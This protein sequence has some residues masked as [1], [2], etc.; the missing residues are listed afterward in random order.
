M[1]QVGNVWVDI[2]GDASGLKRAAQEGQAAVEDL[3]K[4]A[5]QKLGLSGVSD[6]F[7]RLN[8]DLLTGFSQ[9]QNSAN[10]AS[11]SVSSLALAF[12]GLNQAIHVVKQA[13]GALEDAWDFLEEGSRL[14]S[15]EQASYR[16]AQAYDA[17]MISIVASIKEA[18]FNTI[19][20]YDAMK[21][22]NLAMTMGISTNASEI[23]NLMEISIERGRAFGLTT[24][25][26]FDRITRGIG[27]RSTRILDDL[28]FT[29]NAIEAN[30]VYA[31][32]LGIS[33]KELTDDMKVRALFN[34]ILEEGNAELE[35]QG[36]LTKDISTPYQKLATSFKTLMNEAKV[37]ASY[38][39]GQFISSP[40]ETVKYEEQLSSQLVKKGAGYAAYFLSQWRLAIAAD[41]QMVTGITYLS[42][43]QYTE[44][45]RWYG[46]ANMQ[47]QGAQQSV[48]NYSSALEGLNSEMALEIGLAGD[49]AAAQETYDE[50]MKK[51]GRS[52]K[53]QQAAINDLNE[54][55]EDFIL[56]TL[57]S[58]EVAPEATIGIAYAFGEIDDQSLAAF[59]AINKI[60]EMFEVGSDDWIN[61]LENV[62]NRMGDLADLQIGDKSATITIYIRYLTS[63][64]LS[65]GQ[66]AEAGRLTGQYNQWVQENIGGMHGGSFVG[67]QH[68]GIVP[69]GFSNDGFPLMVSSGERVDV[70]PAGNKIVDNEILSKK[71]D[72]LIS[73]MRGLPVEIRDNL[74]MMVA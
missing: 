74:R 46:M 70:T 30:R 15:L 73:V 41:E 40:E 39:F 60:N 9:T 35:K 42:K 27:R 19:T 18:S 58:L 49:L 72:D 8:K 43:S 45:Q 21:A 71:M 47:A 65:S 12:T 63:G 17:N 61:A 36:G 50:A 66:A 20:E 31:E 33:T 44:A 55:Y 23:S 2:G 62:K 28:G 25:E 59:G 38:L 56:N 51:A 14:S 4:V 69:P 13:I 24:E 10:A 32:S 34:Q 68:G 3:K 53:K 64:S 16:L 7:V 52:T 37:G 57:Q 54:S 48:N 6:E 26:A 1:G 67:L 5:Q 11:T 29:A 22:A